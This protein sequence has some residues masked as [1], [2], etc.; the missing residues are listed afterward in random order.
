L[1]A[2]LD[3]MEERFLTLWELNPDSS[4]VHPIAYQGQAYTYIHTDR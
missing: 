1:S 3:V 2:A 4:V